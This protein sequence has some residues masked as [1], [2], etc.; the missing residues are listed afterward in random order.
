MGRRGEWIPPGAPLSEGYWRAL[1][2]DGEGARAAPTLEQ[3]AVWEERL[4]DKETMP[5]RL[6]HSDHVEDAW[7]QARQL[8]A[9]G[10]TVDLPVVGSNRGGVLVAW[11]GLRGFVPA[12][13]LLELT[14]PAD[15]KERQE[16][17]ERLVGRKLSLKIIELDRCRHR[18]VLSERATRIGGKQDAGSFEELNPGDVCQGHVTSLCS[19]G[20]FVDLGGFEGLVH[21][22][23]LS[24]GRVG[25]PKEVLEPGQLVDV[26]VLNVEPDRDRVGLSVKRL[27]PNP[28]ESVEKRYAVG[29]VLEGTV[30]HVVD[31]GAFVQI[32][33][34]LEGLI[35]LSELRT[36]DACDAHDVL[37]AGDRVSVRVLSIDGV[38]HR[39]GLRLETLL[40]RSKTPSTEGV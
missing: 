17:L 7:E 25:H 36:G 22:S 31:F 27:Q 33:D 11:N 9:A 32:E 29:Q 35:H 15:K 13:H 16:A 18:F 39:M 5:R 14:P 4:A 34:G 30:T 12:S 38:R 20:A 6:S 1:L 19:F 26:Y 3:E 24:W 23:E 21:I 37:Q 10:D 28:W 40:S 8:M 2:R